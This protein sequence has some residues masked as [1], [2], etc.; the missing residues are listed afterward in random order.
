MQTGFVCLGWLVFICSLVGEA[1]SLRKQG[2]LFHREGLYII[3][4]GV[5]GARRVSNGWFHGW[6][7]HQFLRF[8]NSNEFWTQVTLRDILS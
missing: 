4:T 5:P 6:E 3:L 8:N 2:T 1:F 7:G